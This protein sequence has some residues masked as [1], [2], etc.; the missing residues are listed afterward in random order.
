[1]PPFCNL[2]L[3]LYVKTD[4]LPVLAGTIEFLP[5][6]DS[7]TSDFPSNLFKL[8]S[9]SGVKQPLW[10]VVTERGTEW[11]TVRSFSVR[12]V[13]VWVCLCVCVCVCV[14]VC[15]CVCV[16][17]CM[18]VCVS[19]R[20]VCV[21]A[22]EAFFWQNAHDVTAGGGGEG[23]NRCVF[24]PIWSSFWPLGEVQNS[25]SWASGV[26]GSAVQFEKVT[27]RLINKYFWARPIKWQTPS[28]IH[29]IEDAK[30]AFFIIEKLESIKV[31]LKSQVPSSGLQIML[32]QEVSEAAAAAAVQF[33][34]FKL[35]PLK[36]AG[37]LGFAFAVLRCRSKSYFQ[38]KISP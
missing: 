19:V 36:A 21:C 22:L 33:P 10:K 1:M 32:N 7:L 20:A 31:L 5:F 16:C 27:S 12:S 29:L 14:C 3:H 17:V 15:L 30:M 6:D 23:D 28:Q 2:L 13:C 26:G 35:C 24:V 8:Q 4:N 9:T 11:S 25:E 37:Q 34:Y 18:C 38:V